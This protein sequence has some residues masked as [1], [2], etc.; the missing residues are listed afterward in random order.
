[1]QEALAGGLKM[2]KKQRIGKIFQWLSHF[3]VKIT[4][5]AINR[6]GAEIVKILIIQKVLDFWLQRAY[7]NNCQGARGSVPTETAIT[8]NNSTTENPR[9]NFSKKF[10]KPL[11]FHHKMWYNKY[12]IKGRKSLEI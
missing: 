5:N 1:M 12:V 4:K 11:D 2:M 10:E 9:K 6:P 7:N 8:V 3:L